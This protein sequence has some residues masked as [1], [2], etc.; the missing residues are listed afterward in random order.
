MQG[1]SFYIVYYV[2]IHFPG[3]RLFGGSIQMW[4]WEDIL[5]ELSRTYF[6]LCLEKIVLWVD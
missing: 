2:T 1:S 3:A 4:R 5:M 6:V